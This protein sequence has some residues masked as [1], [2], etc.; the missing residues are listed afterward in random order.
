MNYEIVIELKKEHQEIISMLN[1]VDVA[2]SKETREKQIIDLR[3]FVVKH[4]EKEDAFVYPKLT[5][6]HNKI[7][8]DLG[9]EFFHSMQEYSH[10]FISVTDRILKS[11]VVL[12]ARLVT[13]YE[14]MKNKIKERIFIEE[15]VLFPAYESLS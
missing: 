6:S 3:A 13:D 11:D 1:G 9:E 12:D 8:I 2:S 14:D 10:L 7:L 5:L 4:L 15:K